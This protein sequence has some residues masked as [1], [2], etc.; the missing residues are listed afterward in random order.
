MLQSTEEKDIVY[1]PNLANQE[2]EVLKGEFSEEDLLC[3]QE[4]CRLICANQR[5]AVCQRII[6]EDIKSRERKS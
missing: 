5:Q 2:T 1:C 4:F 3:H 6:S